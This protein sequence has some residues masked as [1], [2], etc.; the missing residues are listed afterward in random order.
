[1]LSLT[2]G[3]LCRKAVAK[4]GSECVIPLPFKLEK[5]GPSDIGIRP[6]EILISRDGDKTQDLYGTVERIL[7]TGAK[8]IVEINFH[9]RML[10]AKVKR[11]YS[12]KKGETVFLK[13]QDGK[14]YPFD[15]E[16]KVRISQFTIISHIL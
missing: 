3:S 1:M 16:T 8:Q 11:D 13:P 10:L 2:I 6:S 9:N 12:Y 4:I 7:P 14:I 5:Y 15:S